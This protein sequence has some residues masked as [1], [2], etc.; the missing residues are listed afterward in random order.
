MTLKYNKV[1]VFTRQVVQYF[2]FFMVIFYLVLG[3]IFIFS[4]NFFPD[5]NRNAKIIFGAILMIYG[6]FRAYRAFK[7]LHHENPS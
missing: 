2:G 3:L 5:L 1:P 7:S 6:I 4:T